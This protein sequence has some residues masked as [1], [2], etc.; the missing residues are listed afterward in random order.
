MTKRYDSRVKAME[1]EERPKEDYFDAGGLSE[2][3]EVYYPFYQK[4]FEF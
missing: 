4:K 2:Q 3:F 1:V